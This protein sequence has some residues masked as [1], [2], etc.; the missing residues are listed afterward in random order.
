[1]AETLT[2]FAPVS[3]SSTLLVKQYVS[4]AGIADSGK[5]SYGS[6]FGTLHLSHPTRDG[7]QVQPYSRVEADSA[8]Q[9]K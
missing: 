2:A 8:L 4:F 1:M 6:P 9:S 5:R 7:M 3:R